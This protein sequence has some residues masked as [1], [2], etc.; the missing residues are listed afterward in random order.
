MV[1]EKLIFFYEFWYDYIHTDKLHCTKNQNKFIVT[2][3]VDLEA[4]E[5]KWVNLVLDIKYY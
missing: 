4:A 3:L 2:F 5:S 1:H